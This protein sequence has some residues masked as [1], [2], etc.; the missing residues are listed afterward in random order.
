MFETSYTL[1]Y[2]ST[3]YQE[4]ITTLLLVRKAPFSSYGEFQQFFKAQCMNKRLIVL[5]FKLLSLLALV[6]SATQCTVYANVAYAHVA[7]L[8]YYEA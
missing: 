3:M 5:T 2:T 7:T 1:S 6:Y 4:C 8:Y